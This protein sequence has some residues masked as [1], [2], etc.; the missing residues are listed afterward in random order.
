MDT[1]GLAKSGTGYVCCSCRNEYESAEPASRRC[2]C[3]TC[4]QPGPLCELCLNKWM[5]P[6]GAECFVCLQVRK[7]QRLLQRISQGLQTSLISL[8][9]LKE[10]VDSKKTNACCDEHGATNAC[11]AEHGAIATALV[12][13]CRPT[14]RFS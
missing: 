8:A 12:L 9:D 13:R 3:Q 10:L 4:F 11:C 7:R 1:T 2:F 6:N 5:L 14:I